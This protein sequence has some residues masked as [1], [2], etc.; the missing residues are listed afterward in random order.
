[1]TP[2]TQLL[3]A[4]TQVA[5][6]KIGEAL[7]KAGDVSGRSL[8]TR[9]R[10][11]T[12]VAVGPIE[13]LQSAA[14][15]LDA[16]TTTGA[17][18]GLLIS[19]G[20]EAE[21]QARVSANLIALPGLKPAYINNAVAAVRLSSL[22][23]LVWWRG[24]DVAAL[25]GLADLADRIILDEDQPHAAWAKALA[26][27]TETAFGDLRWTRLTPWRAL[28]AQ[29]FDIA[30]VQA[31]APR[32]THLRVVSRDRTSAALYAAWLT[33]SIGLGAACRVEIVQA[34]DSA[35]RQPARHDPVI[36]EVRFGD[37]RQELTMRIGR[38]GNCIK[39]SVAVDG[40][41]STR[42]VPVGADGLDALIGEELRIRAHDTAF[43]QALRVAGVYT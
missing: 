8:P 27:S 11:A 29:F 30:E 7:A 1:M 23:T 6:A 21:P 17:V 43:E 39:T 37:G 13:R 18:R 28:M 40:H 22:P 25:D 5:F 36:E 24:G 16:L 26:L 38:S 14:D 41:E 4:A 32:F 15:A 20:D 9:A 33:A 2:E 42:I 10:I 3:P 31:A 34:S 12:V 19:I 35:A